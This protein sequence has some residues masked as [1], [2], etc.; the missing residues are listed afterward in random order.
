M[1]LIATQCFPPVAGGMEALMGGLADALAGAGKDVLVLADGKGTG[2]ERASDEN[3]PYAVLRF[4]GP[5]PWR[6]WRKRR[7][8]ARCLRRGKIEA[9]FADSWKSAATALTVAEKQDV[10]VFT[11]AHGNDVLTRGDAGRAARI[12]RVF[13]RSTRVVANSRFTAGLVKA[14]GV[15]SGSISIVHPGFTPPPTPSPEALAAADRLMAPFGHRLLTLARLEPR[16]G[17]DQV[18]R[19]LPELLR[20]FP[21]LG[22]VVAGAG[23]DRQRLETL[24]RELGVSEQVCFA[25]RVSEDLKSALLNRAHIFVMPVRED[26]AG[27]SVEGFGIAY[28]E[29]AAM[30]LPAVAGRSG[31]V[32]DAVVHGKTGLLC[33][34]TDT[35]EVCATLASLLAD[36]DRRRAMGEAARMHARDFAWPA[37]IKRYL[38]LM[39]ER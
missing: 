14:L 18:I 29:A 1:I 30:G 35:R 22:Y 21:G 7:A 33:D 26:E 12:A 8:L 16:K 39:T 28:L 15:P 25:G 2:D 13:Q 20:K 4:G 31:G 6:R 23:P 19:C 11:L 37:A 38:A 24:A 5:R 27:H 10:P 36:P 3:R 17:H 32:E 34:G 9:I